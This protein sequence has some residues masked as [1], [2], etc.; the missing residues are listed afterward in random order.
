MRCIEGFICSSLVSYGS[1][2]GVLPY[3]WVLEFLNVIV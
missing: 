2:L 3:D 1:L